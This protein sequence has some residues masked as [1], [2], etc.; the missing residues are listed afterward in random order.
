[1]SKQ[2]KNTDD[3][4]VIPAVH[5]GPMGAAHRFAERMYAGFVFSAAL[6]ELAVQQKEVNK[7]LADA[8][9]F[10]DEILAEI[11]ATD[12]EMEDKWFLAMTMLNIKA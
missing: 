6:E 1:M 3:E 9:H 11:H 2:E 4:G 10:P 8:D 7:A 12:R 5:I